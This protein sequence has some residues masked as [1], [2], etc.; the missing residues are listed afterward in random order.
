MPVILV[1]THKQENAI[2][3]RTSLKSFGYSDIVLAYD[4]M[5]AQHLLERYQCQ[6]IIVDLPFT[7]DRHEI[8]FLL[9]LV[10]ASN[11]FIL[12]LIKRNQL[13]VLQKKIEKYGIFSLSKPV[14]QGALLQ[15]FSFVRTAQCRYEQMNN[16]Q[17]ELLK[18]IKEIKLVDRAKCLLIEHEYLSEE[19]AHKQIEREA[20]D[21]RVT[22]SAIAKRI[23][24][25]LES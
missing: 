21:E 10:K 13:D 6:I 11:A 5:E 16:Q 7:K 19:E 1:C 15:F 23:I 25:R 9:S 3:L 17:A 14:S 22:R 20:M 4:R 24:Q 18:K 8:G 2:L 12:A